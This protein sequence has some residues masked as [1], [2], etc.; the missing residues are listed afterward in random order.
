MPFELQLNVRNRAPM[1]L[2]ALRSSASGLGEHK[3]PRHMLL[4]SCTNCTSTLQTSSAI[5]KQTIAAARTVRHQDQG[6]CSSPGE[7]H[8]T[9]SRTPKYSAGSRLWPARLAARALTRGEGARHWS[10]GRWNL[11]SSR[12]L[13]RICLRTMAVRVLHE[14]PKGD[15][16]SCAQAAEQLIKVVYALVMAYMCPAACGGTRRARNR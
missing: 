5:A 6:S 4:Y 9:E 12:S 14:R 8:Y 2:R 11:R 15:L 3:S 13:F 10:E 16:Q 1:L 7:F